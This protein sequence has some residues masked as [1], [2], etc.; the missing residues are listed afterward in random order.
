M[1]T[2]ESVLQDIREHPEK[3]RHA[4]L[5]DLTRCCFINGAI[6]LSLQEA[7]EGLCGQNGY[8]RCDVR[9]GPCSCGGWH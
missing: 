7:H 3:H 9:S 6:D 4:D 1:R 2:H 8:S 5:N